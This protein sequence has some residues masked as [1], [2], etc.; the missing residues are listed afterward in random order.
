[1]ETTNDTIIALLKRII[2]LLSEPNYDRL[3]LLIIGTTLGFLS[4]FSIYFLQERKKKREKFG[5]YLV[6]V[7][8]LMEEMRHNAIAIKTE[9]YLSEYLST[10]S[11]L[12]KKTNLF[13]NGLDSNIMWINDKV[14]SRL[15]DRELLSAR[16]TGKITEHNIYF[17]EKAEI[18]VATNKLREFEWTKGKFRNVKTIE[19]LDVQFDPN[20][21]T[22]VKNE[23]EKNY[24]PLLFD[25]I[26]KITAS[27]NYGR[28][29]KIKLLI[30]KI[31]KY[32][33]AYKKSPAS[34]AENAA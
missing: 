20:F 33:K 18:K 17:G 15:R 10:K 2:S 13:Q 4:S 5:K 14:D 26:N 29:T 19:E 24:T 6:E 30:K 12:L 28:E 22:M 23:M 21:S 9:G 7:F 11:V 31:K 25:L 32:I 1:M 8:S 34:S 3:S 27:V 16:L